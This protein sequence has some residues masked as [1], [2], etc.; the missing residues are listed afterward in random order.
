MARNRRYTVEYR[1]KREGKTDYKKRLKY[2]DS[3]KIRFVVRRSLRYI[4]LQFVRYGVKGDEVLVGVNSSE[5]KKFG[6][7]YS[8]S[9]IPSAYLSGLL[10]GKRAIEKGIKEAIFDNGLCSIVKKSVLFSC[11]KG[12][13]D[14]GVN[15]P[16]DR[17][18]LPDENVVSGKVIADYVVLLKDET[19]YKKQFSDYL[20]RNLNPSDI[21]KDFNIVKGKIK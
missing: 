2:L 3:G 11:L 1:R 8:F 12:V 21:V 16:C 4:I 7:N 14:A 18:M 15:I 9:N 17:E 6:W 20:K 13:L 5:L 10:I 19:R